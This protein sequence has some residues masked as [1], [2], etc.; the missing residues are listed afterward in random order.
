[1]DPYSSP[2]IIPNNSLHNPFP[3]SLLST[4]QLSYTLKPAS[5]PK[6]PPHGADLEALDSG[7]TKAASG[8]F[9][10]RVVGWRGLLTFG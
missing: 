5:H 4:R 8:V 3:H 7:Q 6:V 9:G 1:M 2:Y 10:F